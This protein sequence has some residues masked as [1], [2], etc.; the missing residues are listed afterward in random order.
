MSLPHPASKEAPK[1]WQHETGGLL[2]PA[3]LRYM[4][5][6]DLS[7]RDL[8][9]I[10][11]YLR[12]WVDSPAWDAGPATSVDRV[13]LALLRTFAHKAHS[14][15]DIDHCVRLAGTLGMDPL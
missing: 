15:G 9:L 2:A 1:Y 12:Q 11:A 7:V 3:I 4:R 14:K 5:G 13:R 10:I 6:Q 8:A